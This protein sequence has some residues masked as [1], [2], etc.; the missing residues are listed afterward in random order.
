MILMDEPQRFFV[1][2]A[3]IGAVGLTVAVQLGFGVHLR[4]HTVSEALQHVVVITRQR[5]LKV[6]QSV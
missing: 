4:T 1:S 5:Y 3:A 6:S 2:T